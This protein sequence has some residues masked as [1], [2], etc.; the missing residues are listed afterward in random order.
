MRTGEESWCGYAIKSTLYKAYP[1]LARK[2]G[3]FKYYECK[4]GATEIPQ[5]KEK[6]MRHNPWGVGTFGGGRHERTP[7]KKPRAADIYLDAK[8]PDEKTVGDDI[9]SKLLQN[10]VRLRVKYVT[11]DSYVHRPDGSRSPKRGNDASNRHENHLHVEFTDDYNKDGA[12]VE[13]FT[14]V[15][16]P[17]S[18]GK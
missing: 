4:A 6:T 13:A 2:G 3:L 8:K 16:P 14:A 11:W 7:D 5:C 12:I 10:A 15:F 9:L 1:I 17:A 18:S